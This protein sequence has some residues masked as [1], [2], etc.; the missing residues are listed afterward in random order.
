[1]NAGAGNRFSMIRVYPAICIYSAAHF[2]ID[3]ACAYLMF[4]AIAASTDGYVCVFIYNFLAFAAQMPLGILADVYDKNHMFAAVGCVLT[5]AAYGL[6]VS[7]VAAAA[8]AGVGNAMFHIGGGL[9]ILNISKS[10][11]GALGIFVSPGAF[12]VYLGT[13]LG[14]GRIKLAIFIIAAL[15]AAAALILA[16]RRAR[17]DACPRN[18][19]FSLETGSSHR[20][21]P[22]IICFFLVV[23]ARSFAGLAFNFP[24]KGAGAGYWGIALIFAVVLGKASGGLL[25][26]R[27]GAAKVAPVSLALAT[28]LFTYSA[29]PAAGVLAMFFF[30]MTM[31]V[32]LWAMAK[33]FPR[34]KGFSFGLLSFGLFVGFLPMYII[35]GLPIAPTWLFAAIAAASLPLL[36]TGLRKA[37]I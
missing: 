10:K 25:A 26:D 15:I 9:D 34:A 13:V 1:M 30:N 31:P 16:N 3:F 35:E 18:A 4:R 7:P 22:A 33:T 37:G 29:L 21:V 24:W 23:C 17:G 2:F 5:A 14:R 36:I 12:G 8:V 28:L 32:T 27:L 11:A 19:P 20:G 6:S